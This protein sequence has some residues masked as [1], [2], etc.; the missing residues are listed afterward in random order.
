MSTI[1]AR[2]GSTTSI[3]ALVKSS[4]GTA[5]LTFQTNS[6]GAITIDANQNA[7]FV[8]VGGVKIPAGTIAQR[9]SPAV[10]GM[11]RYNTTVGNV[12]EGY[13]NGSWVI[14]SG[15]PSNYTATYLMVAGGG[16]GSLNAGNGGSTGG[17][18]AD[19]GSTRGG[20]AD[21]EDA[22]PAADGR[23]IIRSVSCKRVPISFT[24]STTV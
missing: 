1:D 18:S 22:D 17:G 10:N 11:I 16:A 6:L 23:P 5:N 13:A 14:I 12:L 9:P 2:A 3:T 21:D 7:N 24:V 8:S 15:T 19:G 4:D 20:S